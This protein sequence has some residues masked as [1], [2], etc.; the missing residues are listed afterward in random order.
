ME[1][2]SAFTGFGFL[3]G[4]FADASG[5]DWVAV[6]VAFVSGIGR[7]F[8]VDLFLFRLLAASADPFTSPL[9]IV[10]P[11]RVFV[12]PAPV[13]VTSFTIVLLPF[14]AFDFFFF[15]CLGSDRGNIPSPVNLSIN[16]QIISI[17]LLMGDGRTDEA[18]IDFR[19]FC[20]AVSSL[21][22]PPLVDSIVSDIA[23]DFTSNCALLLLG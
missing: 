17:A 18:K 6:I 14:S 5:C 7:V 3:V 16:W 20:T 1:A 2:A 23:R 15:C 10:L 12:F 8:F 13:M 22:A 9:C 11:P 19:I 21:D 4:G